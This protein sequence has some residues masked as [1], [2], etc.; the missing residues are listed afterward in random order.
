MG[1]VADRGG[2]KVRR[3]SA[4]W[5][6]AR[7]CDV[8]L[9]CIITGDVSTRLLPSGDLIDAASPLLCL[10]SWDISTRGPF[11]LS[12]VSVASVSVRVLAFFALTHMA[13]YL[14]LVVQLFVV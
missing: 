3:L 7:P 2:E 4:A 14:H 10:L 9:R 5:I 8:S 1:D 12:S 6:M 13:I 11:L